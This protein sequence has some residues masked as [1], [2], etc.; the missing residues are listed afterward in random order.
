M[1]LTGTNNYTYYDCKQLC[2]CSIEKTVEELLGNEN[3][4]LI[5]CFYDNIADY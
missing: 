1:Y 4:Q 5:L 2:A 3:G